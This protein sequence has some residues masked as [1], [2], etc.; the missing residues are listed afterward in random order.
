[1]SNRKKRILMCG[2]A[3]YTCSGFGVYTNEVMKRL[4]A[5]G[6]YE[7]AELASYGLVND[8]RDT[9][10]NWRIY[11]NAVRDNDPRIDL[12]R[13][14][15]TNQWGEWRF[16]RVCLDFKPDIVIDIRDPWML[17]WE[18]DSPFRRFF[19]LVWM[20]TCDSAPSQEQWL[21]SYK[22]ADGIFTYTDWNLDVLKKEGNGKIKLQ[23]SAPP[24]TNLDIFNPAPNKGKHKESMGF[25]PEM[26]IIGTVMRNQRRK[27][28]P[29]ILDGFR[30]F[31]EN[32]NTLGLH[33]LAQK[34]FLYIH[35]SYPDAGWNFPKLLKESGISHKV[36]FSYLCRAC[37]KWF[38][39]PFQDATTTCV[40]CSSVGSAVLPN[41]AN[42]VSTEVLADIMKCFDVYLQISICEG[43]GMPQMEAASCGVPSMGMPYSAT[44]DILDKTDSI[45]IK[46]AKSYLEIETQAYRMMV[47]SDSL[48]QE[49][50]KFLNLPT[51]QRIK[52]EKKAREACESFYNYDNSAKIWETYLDS[53]ELTGTQGQWDA[54]PEIYDIPKNIPANLDNKQFV[55]FLY[56]DVLHK[57]ELKYSYSALKIISE[58]NLGAMIDGSTITPITREQIFEIFKHRLNNSNICEKARCGL[59]ELPPEDYVNYADMKSK[60]IGTKKGDII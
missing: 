25:H 37:N 24:G 59:V 7:L 41:V 13:S 47:D 51:K 34:T 14:R 20:P 53:V 46:I 56:D 16:D 1:M 6:K 19:H 35:T 54:L 30:K 17:E 4:A 45:P 11:A 23:C 12:Y 50:L 8:P 39:G 32:C 9:N 28:Y 22:E 36:I 38:A 18:K 60:A 2:E 29:D 27:L 43:A 42:G 57:P 40:H 58:L 10:V 3:S 26:N 33:D 55:A 49:L 21:D 52:L 31:I 15:T 44:K 48:A 5:T